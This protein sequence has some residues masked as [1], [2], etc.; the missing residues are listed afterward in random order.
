[1]A[2]QFIISVSSPYFPVALFLFGVGFGVAGGGIAMAQTVESN[3]RV[4]DVASTIRNAPLFGTSLD[5]SWQ[6]LGG[7]ID[8]LRLEGAVDLRSIFRLGL[9]ITRLYQRNSDRDVFVT[10]GSVRGLIR[11]PLGRL[12]LAMGG[13]WTWRRRFDPASGPASYLAVDYRPIRPL[14][15]EIASENSFTNRRVD[16]TLDLGVSAGID[17]VRVRAGYRWL[18]MGVE[19]FSGPTIGLGTQF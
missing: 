6:E 15:L 5:L 1:M 9:D 16:R 18:S 3:Q 8:G 14:T 2:D 7:A 17:L 12:S 4:F 19:D 13:G 10:R 11:V